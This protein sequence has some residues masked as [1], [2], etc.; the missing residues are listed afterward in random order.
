VPVEEL[1]GGLLSGALRLIWWLLSDLL[2]EVLIKGTGYLVLRWLR[3]G[4]K[5]SESAATVAGLCAWAVLG[6]IGFW[7]WHAHAA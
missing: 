3:P 5:P 1:T 7:L 2:L 6:G 4:S